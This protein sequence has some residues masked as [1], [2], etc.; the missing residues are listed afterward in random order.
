M[1][2]GAKGLRNFGYCVLTSDHKKTLRESKRGPNYVY[3]DSNEFARDLNRIASQN[4]P[5]KKKKSNDSTPIL[6][7]MKN[8]RLGLNV[9]SCD[10]LPFIAVVKKT[11][12]ERKQLSN[13]LGKV[14]WDDELMGKFVIAATGNLKDL[15]VI[16]DCKATSG[17]LVIQPNEFGTK[18]KLIAAI[19]GDAS[20]KELK[21][22]L[23]KA[24]DQFKRVAKSHGSHV[25]KGKRNGVNWKTEVPVPKRRRDRRNER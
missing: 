12:K 13:K 6:P 21:A 23:L 24:I 18:G 22:S 19:D 2:D 5:T 17:F 9:A 20:T 3:K 25:R 15:D 10:G 14:V 4:V 7:K 11:T 8:F 16:S 1:F